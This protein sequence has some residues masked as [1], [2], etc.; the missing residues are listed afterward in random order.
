MA[1]GGSQARWVCS[2]CIFLKAGMPAFMS[3]PLQHSLSDNIAVDLELDLQHN[4]SHIHP[5]VLHS[6][7]WVL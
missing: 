1:S 3:M 2:L 4:M 7:P 5:H 6:M